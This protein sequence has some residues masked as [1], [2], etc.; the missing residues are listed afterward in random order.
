MAN[1]KTEI[2]VITGNFLFLLSYQKEGY[3]L[4]NYDLHR[5]ETFNKGTL[6]HGR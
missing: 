6:Q 5:E 3:D 2:Y 1:F 4:V